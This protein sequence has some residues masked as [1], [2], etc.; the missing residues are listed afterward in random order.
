MVRDDV[1]RTF[2]HHVSGF[3]LPTSNRLFLASKHFVVVTPPVETDLRIRG[4]VSGPAARNCIEFD[5]RHWDSVGTMS[6]T[7][8]INNARVWPSPDQGVIDGGGV[9]IRD[10][11]IVQVGRFPAEADTVIEVVVDEEP[12]RAGIDP[13]NK[14]VDR[15]PENN[16]TDVTGS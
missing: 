15:N 11:R 2:V 16:T 10:G 6:T 3:V 13:F 7:T 12:R 1:G 4:Q 14:L 5:S 8:W 9:L